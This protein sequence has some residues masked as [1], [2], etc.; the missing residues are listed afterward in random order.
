MV[1]LASIVVTPEVVETNIII[2]CCIGVVPVID[3]PCASSR[4]AHVRIQSCWHL[5]V[6]CSLSG[7]N[8]CKC[9]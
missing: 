9:P 6:N 5:I 2:Q 7:T 4:N 1:P 8:A 3:S